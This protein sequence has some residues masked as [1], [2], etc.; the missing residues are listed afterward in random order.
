MT[1]GS[2]MINF[3]EEEGSKLQY[4]FFFVL[5]LQTTF[6]FSSLAYSVDATTFA[7]YCDPWGMHEIRG[8][9][10][11]DEIVHENLCEA[12]KRQGDKMNI[13]HDV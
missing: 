13:M 5:H 10:L 12:Y 4:L 6:L 9:E 2:L 7:I 1:G 11:I 3:N 8:R